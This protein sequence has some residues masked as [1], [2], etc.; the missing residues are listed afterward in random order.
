[1]VRRYQASSWIQD[2]VRLTAHVDGTLTLIS[3]DGVLTLDAD[4][5]FARH[6]HEL[7]AL[8]DT[9]AAVVDFRLCEVLFN[10]AEAAEALAPVYADGGSVPRPIAM[11]C[12]PKDFER[13]EDFAFRASYSN[14]VRRAFTEFEP[15]VR[16]TALKGKAWR[17][18]QIELRP[19]R[20]KRHAVA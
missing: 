6:V 5:R 9:D 8:N 3:V 20:R 19:E 1:M 16:W 11:I 17:A 13:F 2:G 7:V 14:A 15:A 12:R 4:P 10:P 18:Q